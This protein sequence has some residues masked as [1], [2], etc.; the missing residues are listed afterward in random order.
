VECNYSPD[1]ARRD[2]DLSIP[3]WALKFLKERNESGLM[4]RLIAESAA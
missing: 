4:E 1:E 2:E 3:E